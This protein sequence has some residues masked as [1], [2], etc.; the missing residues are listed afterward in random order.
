M[1]LFYIITQLL[2]YGFID[3]IITER[4]FGS[5]KRNI[6]L[7]CVYTGATNGKLEACFP[8]HAAKLLGCQKQKHDCL[9]PKFACFQF[10]HGRR[11]SVAGGFI[12]WLPACKI[13]DL[14]YAKPQNT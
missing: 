5:M 7:R 13:Y 4:I 10:A 9:L 14:G 12:A 1:V 2:L 8:S 11:F 3:I 6:V